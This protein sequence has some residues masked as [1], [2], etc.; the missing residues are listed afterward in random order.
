MAQKEGGYVQVKSR[1][2]TIRMERR[3]MKVETADAGFMIDDKQVDVRFE[4]HSDDVGRLFID[5]IGRT[6]HFT[7]VDEYHYDIW[8]CHDVIRVQVEDSR[9]ALMQKFSGN[10]ASSSGQTIITAPMPGLVTK[11]QV[12]VGD[13]VAPGSSLIILEA[14]KMENEIRSRINGIVKKIEVD[15]H[16]SVDK[17]Q[18]LITLETI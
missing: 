1:S 14:M 16:A 10:V 11:L 15:A 8:V 6:V 17:G 13:T 9:F 5:G 7:R 3:T 18:T 2:W 4:P 12:K